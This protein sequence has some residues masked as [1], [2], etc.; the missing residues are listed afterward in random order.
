MADSTDR[1]LFAEFPPISAEEWRARVEQDLKGKSPE[2]LAWDTG[3][4]FSLR[5]YYRQEDLDADQMALKQGPGAW[6][7]RRGNAFN[8]Q[9][10]GWQVIQELPLHTPELGVHLAEARE[11]GVSAFWLTAE[12]AS[13]FAEQLAHLPENLPLHQ[14]ALHLAF[15][16]A[17]S[18]V[19]SDLYVQ[20][21]ERNLKPE[22]LTG[23]LL[24][25]PI[26]T[27]LAS[28][29]VPSHVELANAEAGVQAFAASPWFRAVG[30]DLSW[31]YRQ[32]G[33]LSQ[34][35]AI[36]LASTVEYLDF[37]EKSGSEAP[38]AALLRKLAFTFPVGT[39]FF[40][41]MAKFRSFR[42]LMAR[43]L[44]AYD[45]TDAE[46]ASPFV[47][48]RI[49]EWHY[50]HYDAYN[51]LLRGTTGAMSAIMGG[52]QGLVIPAFD[53]LE[54]APTATSLRLARNIQHLLQ[55]ESYLDQVK[56][57]AGGSYYLEQATD[58]LAQ[59]AWELFQ[60][61][62]G[63]GGLLAVAEAGQLQGWI[64]AARERKVDR[65]ATRRTTQVGI[66]QYA[67]PSETQPELVIPEGDQR[68]AAPFER[69]RQRADAFAARRGRRLQAFL[70][71]FGEA[72][73]RN[74]RAQFA[75]NLLGAGGLEVVET[76]HQTDLEQALAEAQAANPE[77]LVLCAAD[78]DYFGQGPAVLETLREALP[79]TRF[80]LAGQPENWATLAVDQSIAARMNALDFLT[81][82]VDSLTG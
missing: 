81:E 45:I 19:A 16:Q 68:L 29:Q 41:E 73:M 62:E 10:Q 58:G 61:I 44:E 80:I 37:L 43:M 55:H 66:N 50:T 4:G 17:P 72:R 67:H 11:A 75:R 25:D 22:L 63:K 26:G 59:S 48:G 36:A 5:P 39:S 7:L 74:A 35:L 34:Q 64:A 53:M 82:L 52:V 78:A 23:T 12:D 21:A 32:G 31:V 42:L 46:L 57:P 47:M 77:V 79:Q 27:A 70:L 9:D 38:K 33:N 56:D 69:I 54:G 14:T 49:S 1:T 71:L 76:N 40:L 51:N 60:D 24:N 13:S 3:E 15:G 6:P 30:V 2:K 20:L 65:L 8:A 18:L 28:G